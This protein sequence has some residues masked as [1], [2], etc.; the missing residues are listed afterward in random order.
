MK[1]RHASAS[2]VAAMLASMSTGVVA[3]EAS[4]TDMTCRQAQDF[5]VSRGA[6]TIGTGGRTYDRFVADRRHCEPTEEVRTAFVPTRDVGDA[7]S[8]TGVSSLVHQRG[9]AVA[10]KA[11][12]EAVATSILT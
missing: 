12:D 7:E 2:L 11:S 6:V 1:R 10:D 8:D 9:E 3:Q 4:S 5:V